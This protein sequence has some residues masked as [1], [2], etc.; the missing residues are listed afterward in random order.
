MKTI[1]HACIALGLAGLSLPAFAD[2]VEPLKGTITYP[3]GRTAP[4][5]YQ[6]AFLNDNGQTYFHAGKQKVATD[7]VPPNYILNMIVGKNGDLYVPE[8]AQGSLHGFDV[9]VGDHRIRIQ[10]TAPT[11][12]KQASLNDYRVLIDDRN[13]L[14]DTTHPTIMFEFD[15]TGLIGI[16]GS[17]YKK[18][19]SA[20]SIE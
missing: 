1:I 10:R 8:F 15:D 14:L 2:W 5:D 3:S 9:R 4:L 16:N 6:F 17:G 18:D 19:L 12:S 13:M 20:K 11:D 7:S